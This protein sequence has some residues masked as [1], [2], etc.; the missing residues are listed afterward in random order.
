LTVVGLLRLLLA[1]VLLVS[2]AAKLAAG[3]SGREALGSYGVESAN[4]QR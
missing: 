3:R 2:A 4:A 1:A